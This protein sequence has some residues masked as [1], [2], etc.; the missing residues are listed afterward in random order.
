[1]PSLCT[2]FMLRKI[3]TLTEAGISQTHVK[4]SP[5]VWE[6]GYLPTTFNKTGRGFGL[7]LAEGIRLTTIHKI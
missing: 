6:F 5:E 7:S 2:G 1:M 4:L 3:R